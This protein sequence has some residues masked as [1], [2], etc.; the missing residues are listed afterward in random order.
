MIAKS[1]QQLPGGILVGH[2]QNTDALTGCSVFLFPQAVISA[3]DIRGSA[4]ATSNFSALYP[5]HV[6]PRVHG[7][8]F[9][10][11]S[12]FGLNAVSGVQRFLEE[13]KTGFDVGVTTI[14]IVPAA[15]IFDLNVG[16]SATRPDADMAYSACLNASNAWPEAGSV[17]AGTGASV[18]KYFGVKKAMRGGFGV[19]GAST[20]GGAEVVAFCT[21]N[22]F[23]DVWEPHS[24]RI[25]AGSRIGENETG[26]ANVEQC[27]IEGVKK[28]RFDSQAQSVENTTLV[29][30]A[31]TAA[32]DVLDAKKLA[33]SAMLGL[34]DSVRPAC[35]IYDGDLAIATSVGDVK[36][37][38]TTL[39]VF[40]RRVVAEAIVDGVK[41][42]TPACGL[43][44]W[45]SVNL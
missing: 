44:A 30:V 41:K 22:A 18:G 39:C 11:G 31:T 33:E 29:M 36:E 9:T 15:G 34:V 19:A 10:G 32:L 20:A 12:V 17:G 4:P 8:L 35:T 24:N 16:E 21:V 3:A 2:A 40:A 27:I 45:R 14:P 6:Y 5:V 38:I 7:V 37:D 25:L 23:G 28:N 1:A 26:F 42:A 13:R 43:P